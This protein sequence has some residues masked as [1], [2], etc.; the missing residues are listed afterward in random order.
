MGKIRV[1]SVMKNPSLCDGYGYRTVVFLQ[2]CD[3]HCQG[4]HNKSTWATD[5]GTL[6]EVS[7]L[8]ALLREQSIN[9]KVTISGGEPL[10]Q[11]EAVIELLRELSDFDLCL[12]TG[13][14]LE[15][16]PEE[17]LKYLKYI[18]VG[19]F[20]LE[21]R[22]STKPFVGSTNQKFVRIHHEEAK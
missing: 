7:D 9:K 5:K 10:L 17:I 15:E 1:N 14:E 6:M 13:H 8:A 16:V 21:Q 2:G 20:I 19:R 4:C 3:L 18:K 11:K 12:Y 22:T